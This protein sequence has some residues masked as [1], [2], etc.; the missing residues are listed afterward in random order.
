MISSPK[1]Y[2]NKAIGEVYVKAVRLLLLGLL[3]A[4]I[5]QP[6]QAQTAGRPPADSN[7][8]TG[9]PTQASQAP[10]EVMKKLSDLV[11]AGK[12][13]EAQQSVNALLILYPDDQRLIKAKALLDKPLASSKTA[14]SAASTNP[15][16]N[17]LASASLPTA[18]NVESYAGMDK[19]EYNS[20]MELASQAQRT[21]DL[22]Q[23]KKLLQQF[24]DRSSPFL[25]NHPNEMLLWQVRAFSAISVDDPFA[26]YEAGQKLLATETAESNDANMHLLA[27]LNLKGWL[28][29]EKHQAIEREKIEA[30]WTDPATGYI[31]TKQD[32]GSDVSFSQAKD[33]CSNLHLAGYATWQLPTTQEI[34]AINGAVTQGGIKLS[35]KVR[36]AWTTRSDEPCFYMFDVQGHHCANAINR[37]LVRALCMRRPIQ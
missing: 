27:Q 30:T 3:L 31:W 18:Q 22:E 13:A 5:L 10:D 11:H 29:K 19:V 1:R 17:H 7:A 36:L 12:Y 23:Q 8:T 20:L 28:D 9:N 2:Q 25:Q 15:P 4:Q 32:N 21:T 33:Y 6:L 35:S 26:G 37:R 16:V 14:D 34:E 24:L